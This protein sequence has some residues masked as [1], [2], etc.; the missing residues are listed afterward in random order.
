ME[1]QEKD[2]LALLELGLHEAGELVAE[3]GVE[4]LELGTLG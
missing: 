1:V 3:V 4:L 2:I